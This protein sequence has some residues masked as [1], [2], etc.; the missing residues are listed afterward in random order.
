MEMFRITVPATTANIGPGFDSLGIA[1]KLYNT[2][3]VEEIQEGLVIEVTGRDAALIDT[4]ENNLVYR[5]IKKL[6][7]K[8]EYRPKGLRI[9]QHNEIP[10]SRGL[11]SSAASIIGGLLAGNKLANS[12]LSTEKILEMAVEMEGHPDNVAP[13]LLG[14]MVVSTKGNDGVEFVQIPIKESLEFYAAIPNVGLSTKLAREALPKTIDYKDAV[15]N[16]GK[17][18]LLVSAFATG[19]YD[20]IS[21]GLE[22]K[23]HQP[24]RL[25]L[26]DS[27]EKIFKEASRKEL[28]NIFLSGAGPTV[29]YLSWRQDKNDV[30]LFK[31]IVSSMSEEWNVEKLMVHNSNL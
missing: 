17:V 8:V 1:L 25:P 29:I 13:A 7:D 16:V 30:E 6:L 18:A 3:E 31:E 2:I 4:N 10:I 9:V 5:S 26:L 15:F 12:M 21:F 27:L 23:L 11:G 22:D 28:K 14:G 24:Y 19:E 20:K